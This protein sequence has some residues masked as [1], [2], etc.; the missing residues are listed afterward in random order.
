MEKNKNLKPRVILSKIAEMQ[1]INEDGSVSFSGFEYHEIMAVLHNMV[2][3]SKCA[4]DIEQHSVVHTAVSN[5]AKL[6]DLTESLVI[7]EVNKQIRTN[8]N[9]RE[10]KYFLLTSISI[11]KPYPFSR[12]EIDGCTIRILT[13]HYPKKYINRQNA[14]RHLEHDIEASP[15]SYAKVIVAVHS[16]SEKGAA[17]KALNALDVARSVLCLFANSSMEIIGDPINPINNVRLGGAHTIH[18][19]NGK[20]HE[21]CCW[22]EPNFKKANTFK[23]NNINT[24]KSNTKW[25]LKQLNKSNYSNILKSSLL[26]FV[27]AL[28]EK[29][30]NIALLRLWGALEELACPDGANY[31]LVIRRVSFLFLERDYHKQVLEHLR[32]YRNSNVHAGDESDK[33]KS[34]CFQLQFF[35]YELILFH[36]KNATYFTSLEEANNFL[37][38]PSN[39][40]ALENKKKL[41]EKAIKFVTPPDEIS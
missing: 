10:E 9:K 5:V 21:A 29:D 13:F 18:S 14:L 20:A 40:K 36:I 23:P 17:T 8:L 34:H 7:E 38:L 37:D 4:H 27:R 30:K 11:K 39:I 26:R 31:D 24:F 35:Y 25:F 2:D 33:A 32:E 1:T 6:G 28:D 22:F 15:T 3:F 19:K 12:L 41:I 16:K